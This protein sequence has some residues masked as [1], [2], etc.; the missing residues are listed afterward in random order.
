MKNTPSNEE[1]LAQLE[2]RIAELEESIPATMLLHHSFLARCF[3][4]W[5]LNFVAS[6]IISIPM[7]ILWVVIVI[8]LLS[9]AHRGF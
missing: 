1:R 4:V 9:T 6:L 8:G 7:T 2:D 3:A 5:G